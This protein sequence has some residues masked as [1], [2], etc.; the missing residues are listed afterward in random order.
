MT[1]GEG[2]VDDDARSI[3]GVAAVVRQLSGDI[4]LIKTAQGGWELP[5]GRVERGEDLIG[6]LAREVREETGCRVTVGRL[7]GV[8]SS[9]DRGGLFLFTFI[10]I[11]ASG[12][13]VPGDDSLDAGWF[14]PED[15]ARMVTHPG[16]RARLL[17]ALANAPG[18]V[19]RIYEH[20]PQGAVERAVHT[21]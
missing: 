1:S 8:T 19:Y 5:G 14:P 18:V 17:D 10:G 7:T 12:E 21:I 20:T 13:P 2:V 16:E 6:A 3:V 9:P 15:A 4:L 11:H